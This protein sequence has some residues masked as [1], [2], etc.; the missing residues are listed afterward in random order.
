MR[1]RNHNARLKGVNQKFEPRQS[2]TFVRGRT[3]VF[4]KAGSVRK[5]FLPLSSPPPYFSFFALALFLARPEI[6]TIGFRLLETLATQA[7]ISPN[8]FSALML[9]NKTTTKFEEE[10]IPQLRGNVSSFYRLFFLNLKRN[11]I[12]QTHGLQ[13][14]ANMQVKNIRT[15]QKQLDSNL[16]RSKWF[17]LFNSNWYFVTLKCSDICVLSGIINEILCFKNELLKYLPQNSF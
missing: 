7:K 14:L 1:E 12:Q 9:I 6:G 5:R 15:R 13:Q 16:K 4:K 8:R 10:M 11:L 17:Q 2:E 3:N